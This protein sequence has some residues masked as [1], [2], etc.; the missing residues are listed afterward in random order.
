M[1]ANL[2]ASL[3]ADPRSR[4]RYAMPRILAYRNPALKRRATFDTSRRD[5]Y[6]T[7]TNPSPAVPDVH[8][9]PSNV[10]NSTAAVHEPT[11]ESR[12]GP[13]DDREDAEDE[14]EGASDE[15][16]WAADEAFFAQ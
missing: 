8:S 7:S 10:H 12:D 3:T 6:T 1:N 2:R 11:G 9:R 14:R 13:P 5:E 4:D 15:R 16:E